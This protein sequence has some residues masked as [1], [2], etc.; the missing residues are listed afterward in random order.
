VNLGIDIPLPCS[1]KSLKL[2][3]VFDSDDICPISNIHFYLFIT[4]EISVFEDLFFGECI[5]DQIGEGVV[6]IKRI[7][8]CWE[9]FS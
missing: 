6:E 2:A 7:H 8:G 1:I 3:E 4:S 9:K 5:I